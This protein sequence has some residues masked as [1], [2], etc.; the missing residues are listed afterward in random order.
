[1]LRA[2][3]ARDGGVVELCACG[4]ADR[5][6]IAAL[7][8][9][10]GAD[11]VL[12][13]G[14]TGTGPD[15]E[16]PLALAAAGTLAI[17]GIAISPGASAGMGLAGDTPVV[18]LPGS[19]LACLCAYDLFAGRLIRRLGGR[20]SQ[21]PYLVRNATVGRK[22]VSAIGDVEL[23]R[24]RLIAGEAFPSG[25]PDSG[26]LASVSRADGFV[27]IPAALEGYAPG[28]PVV[29]HLYDGADDSRGDRI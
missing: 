4:I 18:L 29:V 28:T 16:A 1:M 21:L 20:S 24:V 15:D 9:P 7:I 8:A 26:G 14:R 10:P 19:P 6:A 17:H 27:L 22:I 25:S 5:A 13:C 11:V 3:V 2:L 12:V 23:C